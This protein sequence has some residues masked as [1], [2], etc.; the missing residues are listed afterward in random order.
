MK[1]TPTLPSRSNGSRVPDYLVEAL[2]AAVQM[3]R[4]VVGRERVR[5]AVERELALR[6]PVAVAADDRAEVRASVVDVVVERVEAEDDVVEL[7]AA[8]RHAQR[9]DDRAVGHRA[10]L[11]AVR[12]W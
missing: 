2:D 1:T 5:L 6:D 9:D 8:V 3:V 4:A 10:H 7:A 12:R 11:H